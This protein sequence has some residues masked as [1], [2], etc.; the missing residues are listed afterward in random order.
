M[1]KNDTKFQLSDRELEALNHYAQLWGRTWKSKMKKLWRDN[2]FTDKA[3]KDE[4][5]SL[6]N[7]G[8]D[9]WLENIN[10]RY[11][12]KSA[13]ERKR[14]LVISFQIVC[15]GDAFE[16]NGIKE[17]SDLFLSIRNRV[18]GFDTLGEFARNGNVTLRDSNGNK[19]ATLK[20][21]RKAL[22]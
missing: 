8:G 20:T 9:W 18:S 3:Y 6:K 13:D 16:V 2:A 12:N 17:V 1:T 15:E 14:P 10:L 7:L 21:E 11:E 22:V 19:C 4:L 5:R